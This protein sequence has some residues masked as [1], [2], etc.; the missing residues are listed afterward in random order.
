M[1]YTAEKHK[2]DI[3]NYSVQK[4]TQ[5]RDIRTAKIGQIG[6]QGDIYFIVVPDD[7]PRGKLIEER[8]L[9][10][11]NGKG[12]RHVAPANAKV[13]E[14]VEFPAFFNDNFKRIRQCLGPV[15]VIED[16]KAISTHPEHCNYVLPKKTIQVTF[17]SDVRTNDRTR[18]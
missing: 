18:D 4:V 3:V 13:F 14:G 2:A 16:D 12:S 6:R 11:G 5:M 9:V 7:H 1:L 15:I 17:Q 8:Q 10:P